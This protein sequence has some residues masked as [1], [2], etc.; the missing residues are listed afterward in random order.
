[1]VE[2]K[3]VTHRTVYRLLRQYWRGGKTMNALFSDHCVRVQPVRQWTRKNGRKSLRARTD[4][5]KTGIVVTHEVQ[6]A[7]RNAVRLWYLKQDRLPLTKVYEL[8]LGKYFNNGYMEVD[9]ALTPIIKPVG[10]RPT[11]RQ[12]RYWVNKEI[13]A[14]RKLKERF[15]TRRYNLSHRPV[16]GTSSHRAAGP[17][18]Y[19]QIDAMIAD[20]YLVHRVNREWCIGKPVVYVVLDVFSHLIAG[21]YVGLEGPSWLGAMMALENA[22]SDKVEYCARHGIT[23]SPDE[24]PAHHL[25]E[26]ITADRGEMLGKKPEN[27]IKTLWVDVENL[28]PFRP[29]WKGFIER[30]FKTFNEDFIHWLAGA[31][32]ERNL[33]RGKRHWSEDALYDLEEFEQL[34]I[35]EVLI[36]NNYRELTNFQRDRNMIADDVPPVPI[37]LWNWGRSRGYGHL[38]SI[39]RDVLRL[40]L[41]PMETVTV[42]EKGIPFHGRYYSC[43]T[44]IRD[45]WFVRDGKTR[46]VQIHYDPRVVDKIFLRLDGGR[47]YEECTLVDIYSRY[48][49]LRDEEAFDLICYENGVKRAIHDDYGIQSQAFLHAKIEQLEAEAKKKREGRSTQKANRAEMRTH[50]QE[51]RMLKREEEKWTD[52]AS[53]APKRNKV[54]EFPLNNRS[55][56]APDYTDLIGDILGLNED[57]EK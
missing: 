46:K 4:P 44:A 53:T 10:E 8:M 48:R 9:G 19:Y 39:E 29:D 41:L 36:Y 5:E 40:N 34:L 7:F 22:C 47:A 33:E 2:Q 32:T 50:R 56:E 51:E 24:W 20:V 38:R 11:L 17:G 31:V 35:H 55:S 6:T 52:L 15:G 23:I 1:M 14:Q 45:N 26:H 13:D 43:D 12:F 28:P 54:V 27:F 57:D 25:P 21:L 37:H 30:Q 49:G 42:S 18:Q 3:G 16:L